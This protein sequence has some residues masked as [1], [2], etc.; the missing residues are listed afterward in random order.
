LLAVIYFLTKGE[1]F[2]GVVSYR[3]TD[4]QEFYDEALDYVD[5]LAEEFINKVDE[6]F[7]NNKEKRRYIIKKYLDF[8]DDKLLKCL[9]KKEILK[10]GII[11]ILE[12][13]DGWGDFSCNR[14]ASQKEIMLRIIMSNL[15]NCNLVSTLMISTNSNLTENFIK[16]CIYASSY[17][18]DFNEWDD[19]HVEVVASCAASGLPAN[20]CKELIEL[21][22][23]E[24]LNNK[25]ISTKFDFGAFNLN[26]FSEEFINEFYNEF[27]ANRY[28]K[29][30]RS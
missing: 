25:R 13:V 2:M 9:P 6:K 4:E 10:S 11:L 20:E 26:N 19:K 29:E 12:D 27:F 22:G 7:V 15:F 3:I 28:R 1:I 18:F 24:R 23:K 5:N 17:L 14:Y 21:Y 16:D 30:D 8:Q